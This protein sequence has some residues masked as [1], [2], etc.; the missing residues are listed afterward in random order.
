[1]TATTV[2]CA[3]SSKNS[4]E[5]PPLEACSWADQFDPRTL[6]V[7]PAEMPFDPETRIF[8]NFSHAAEFSRHNHQ[9]PPAMKLISF[10]SAASY[11]A[12]GASVIA[13]S[14]NAEATGIYAASAAL[15]IVLGAIRD[16]SPRTARWE[17]SRS[18]VARFPAA[19]ATP[20]ERL[21]A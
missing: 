17:P 19:A 16:Y 15:L 8:C 5:D 2:S 1:M 13:A 18:N 9:L 7:H 12:L 20:S 3:R 11:L 21:A 6:A 14:L 4:F 10:L